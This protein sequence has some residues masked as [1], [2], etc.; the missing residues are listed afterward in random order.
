MMKYWLPQI[1]VN[2]DYAVVAHSQTRRKVESD[3]TLALAAEGTGGHK[4][5]LLVL[6]RPTLDAQAQKVKLFCRRLMLLLVTDYQQG[7]AAPMA[8]EQGTRA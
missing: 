2:Q 6:G 5:A 3:E 7:P 4:E 8:H 1:G